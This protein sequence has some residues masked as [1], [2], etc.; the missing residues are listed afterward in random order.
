L[1][2]VEAAGVDRGTWHL[3]TGLP[4]LVRFVGFGIRRP[5]QP[6]PGLDVSGQVVATGENVGDF[7][8]GDE[9]IGIGSGTFAEYALAESRKLAHRPAAIDSQMVA[10]IPVSGITALQAV[11]DVGRIKPGQCVLVV[12][13]SGGVG[14]FA[15]QL[16]R[17]FG[18]R[19]TGVAS[20]AKLD[21]VRALGAEHV[22]DYRVDNALDGSRLY[23]LIID[24][25]G[26]N[27]IHE[28]RRGLTRSGTLVI[29]GGEGGDRFT[30]GILRQIGATLLSLFV[31]QRLTMFISDENGQDVKTLVA[32]LATGELIAP[33][34]RSYEFD[35]APSAI[36]DLAAGR[37]RGKAIIRIHAP[38]QPSHA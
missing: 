30:G 12:G 4:Y 37:V 22:F 9:V 31:S 6:V 28:L 38:I 18:A 26:R 14:S 7:N 23:D 1:I 20:A 16:A 15:V 33:V 32:M 19:V 35:E 17:H 34:E 8:V 24:I 21:L 10:A 25:G 13:A 5:K 3:M 11:R 27:P 29:V 36:A 2:K